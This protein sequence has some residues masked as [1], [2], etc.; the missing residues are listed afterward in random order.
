MFSLLPLFVALVASPFAAWAGD[1]QGTSLKVEKPVAVPP[2]NDAGYRPRWADPNAKP[3]QPGI[4]S[5]PTP[6]NPADVDANS[7]PLDIKNLD[8]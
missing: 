1:E 5:N 2:D 3:S 6:F 4:E 7:D 8:Q